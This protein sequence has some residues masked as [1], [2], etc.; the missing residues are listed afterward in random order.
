M[1]KK[2]AVVLSG[3]GYLDGAEITEAV[4][5]LIALG[6]NHLEYQ[7]FA[8]NIDVPEVDHLTGKETGKKINVLKEA[9]R[10][11]RG[12]IL[13]LEELSEANFKALVLPGGYGAAKNLSNFATKGST[14]EVNKVLLEKIEAF[15]A[16]KKPIA[17]FCIA[18]AT[19][20]LALG[21]K[22]VTVTIGNDKA[23]AEE[24]KKT[25]A[26]H[27]DCEV[28]DFVIDDK[29][30]VITSPAYMYDTTPVKA[31]TGILKAIQQLAT[32]I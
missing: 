10:I 14:G 16:A 4:A 25:G 21:K 3:C 22:G 23:T 12:K 17:A 28:D 5:T 20:A 27:Q 11:A 1:S 18:P 26:K 2:I 8:P 29:N 32:I 24:V 13:P 30:K 31:Y 9:A 19:V 6:Q 7:C 15:H